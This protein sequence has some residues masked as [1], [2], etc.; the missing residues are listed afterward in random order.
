MNYILVAYEDTYGELKSYFIEARNNLN[1][2]LLSKNK[3]IL[4][5]VKNDCS[6]NTFISNCIVQ[7][8]QELNLIFYSHGDE[9]SIVDNNKKEFLNYEMDL[10]SIQINIFYST[11]CETAKGKLKSKIIEYS[12]IFFGYN[13]IAYVV[14][15][16]DNVKD[17]FIECDNFCIKEI[18]S[19]IEDKNLLEIKTDEFFKE[20]INQFIKKDLIVEAILL[21]HNKESIEIH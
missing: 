9:V 8:S 21:M 4:N 20:Q 11:A 3:N 1:D 15:G 19:G 17:I 14:V 2:F 12:N 6:S 18:A 7:S 5:D 10:S 13:S 16:N